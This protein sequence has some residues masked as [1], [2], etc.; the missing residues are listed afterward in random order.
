MGDPVM[1]SISSFAAALRHADAWQE[2]ARD[3]RLR[4]LR[5]EHRADKAERRVEL[6]VFAALHDGPLAAEALLAGVGITSVAVP[7]A[8]TRPSAS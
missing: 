7:V 6:L 3:W 2:C 5:A 1:V 4:A 8:K